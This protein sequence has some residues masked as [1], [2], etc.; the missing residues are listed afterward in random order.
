LQT[1]RGIVAVTRRSER[2]VGGKTNG[3][4]SVLAD[5]GLFPSLRGGCRK[6]QTEEMYLSTEVV[7]D[8]RPVKSSRT[9]SHSALGAA[10]MTW[11]TTERSASRRIEAARQARPWFD[12]RRKKT[13]GPPQSLWRR[14]TAGCS[15]AHLRVSGETESEIFRE[16]EA[17]TSSRANETRVLEIEAADGRNRSHA[18]R[19]WSM[20]RRKTMCVLYKLIVGL[21]GQPL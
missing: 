2:R 12:P 21:R 9:S 10:S 20:Q 13:D 19:V 18:S 7:P 5:S 15:N 6:T 11:A 1:Q 16:R 8:R 14:E 4:P 3:Q 17:G